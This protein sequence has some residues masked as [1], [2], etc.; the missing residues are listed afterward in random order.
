MKTKHLKRFGALI[1]LIILCTCF[2][3]VFVS[4]KKD[5]T[6]ANETTYAT[7]GAAMTQDK[8]YS[9][10]ISLTDANL[11]FVDF[12]KQK[13]AVEVIDTDTIESVRAISDYEITKVS[14]EVLSITFTDTDY[15]TDN[16]FWRLSS[17]ESVMS[18]GSF[19]ECSIYLESVCYGLAS[20]TSSINRYEDNITLTLSLTSGKLVDTLTKEM[21]SVAGALAEKEY[22]LTRVNDTTFKMEYADAFKDD[23]SYLEETEI[24]LLASA[25]VGNQSKAVSISYSIIAPTATIDTSSMQFI[26][27]QDGTNVIVPVV[28]E[29]N[30]LKTVNKTDVSITEVDGFSVQ[31]IDLVGNSVMLVTLATALEKENAINALEAGILKIAAGAVNMNNKALSIAF[32]SLKN[33]ISLDEDADLSSGTFDGYVMSIR[34]ING[35]F[36]NYES[37]SA[38]DISIKDK[39]DNNYSFTITSKSEKLIVVKIST[40]ATTCAGS[41]TVN[42][43]VIENRFGLAATDLNG[44]F[45]ASYVAE[46]KAF[47]E[48]AIGLLTK[49]VQEAVSA[50]ASTIGSKVGAAITPYILSFLGLPSE[51][52]IRDVNDNVNALG[53]KLNTLSSE[54]AAST[55]TILNAISLNQYGQIFSDY[56][57]Y[58]DKVSYYVLELYGNQSGLAKLL[59]MEADA[60]HGARSIPAASLEQLELNADYQA[61]RDAFITQFEAAAGGTFATVVNTFGNNMIAKTFGQEDGYLYGLWGLVKCKY[62]W[63]VQTIEIK[64]KFLQTAGTAYLLGMGATMRYLE[65]KNSA[66]R[67]NFATNFANVSKV[68][69]QYLGNL[70]KSKTYR[71]LGNTIEYTTSKIV[72]LTLK[73]YCTKDYKDFSQ[74]KLAGSS[75][76]VDAPVSAF[77]QEE[78]RKIVASANSKGIDF[79]KSLKD[80]GFKNLPTGSSLVV[81]AGSTV[82]TKT[83]M[84]TIVQQR[85]KSFASRQ[86]INGMVSTYS[87]KYFTVTSKSVSDESTRVTS[88]ETTS[89]DPEYRTLKYQNTD[90]KYY[91]FQ[92]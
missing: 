34:A 36:K 65:Y 16:N 77:S 78:L 82:S 56:N 52:T 44:V 86:V 21:I 33:A 54:L 69:D 24:T 2:M 80:A 70:T 42:S 5:E 71:T 23:I 91:A 22:T 8:S 27:V 6:L 87:A 66:N 62:L 19:L 26:S 64:D 90:Y 49:G 55:S 79:I 76:R 60:A 11:K 45:Q 51:V 31:S 12:D 83:T 50:A 20:D 10:N 40:S 3:L 18:D 39:S 92:Y 30:L 4:C 25:I 47:A 17:T 1:L 48:L 68:L 15:I 74:S 13:Y 29:D 61:A 43:S 89:K 46:D 7:A 41:V 57:T 28:V 84:K 58:Y 88:I 75:G 38:S 72:Q 35:T 59:K 14:D 67:T 9:A 81:S 53:S 73:V 32:G 37:I 85:G 63:D